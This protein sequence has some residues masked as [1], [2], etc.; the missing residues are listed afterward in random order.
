MLLCACVSADVP[1]PQCET[2][3]KVTKIM[4]I[5]NLNCFLNFCLFIHLFIYPKSRYFILYL[6]TNPSLYTLVGSFCSS[7]CLHGEV[8]VNP[9]VLFRLLTALQCPPTCQAA[10]AVVPACHEMN[11]AKFFE[12]EASFNLINVPLLHSPVP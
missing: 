11:T 12:K 2:G 8:D 4:K 3:E 7:F 10:G 6:I 5:Y 9:T 1:V